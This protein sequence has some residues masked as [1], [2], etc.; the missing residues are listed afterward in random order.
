MKVPDVCSADCQGAS[1]IHNGNAL[2]VLRMFPDA[3]VNC[4][5]TSPP[6]WGL[7]DYEKAKA[8]E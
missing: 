8:P 7:R 6:Y 2:S 4:C 3:S 5:V 1:V